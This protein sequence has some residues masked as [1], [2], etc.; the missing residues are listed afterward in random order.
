M[1]IHLSSAQNRYL[2]KNGRVANADSVIEAEGKFVLP[3]GIDPNVNLNKPYEDLTQTVDDFYRGTRAAL[4]GGTTTVVDCVKPKD[5][6]S[7]VEAY[8]KWR[9]WAEG[10][11]CCNYAL[12]MTLDGGS[13]LDEEKM[14]EMEE[15]TGLDFGIN[16][17]K[18]EMKDA[19]DKDILKNLEH[20]RKLG[21]LA[22]ITPESGELT[23]REAESLLERGINGP[24]GFA[25]AHSESAEE[26]AVMRVSTLANHAPCP[27]WVGPVMSVSAAEILRRKK[28]SGNVVFG[29]TIPASL[30]C[31]GN[32]YWNE[33]WRH[34]AGFVTNPPIRRGQKE[35]M[36]QALVNR[37]DSGLDFVSSD[38]ATFNSNQKALGSG[39]FM[40]IP[41]GVNGIEERMAVLWEKAVHT[42]KMD[43]TEFVELT[44]AGPAK[45][46]G[47]YPDKGRIEVGAEADLVV[48]NP[49]EKR[50]ISAK[51]H[52]LKVDFNIFEGMEVHG[53]PETVIC[54]GKIM[55]DEGQIRVMQGFG[56]FIPLSPFNDYVYDKVRDKEMRDAEPRPVI[57]ADEP[58]TS[59]NGNGIPPPTP[60][61]SDQAERAPSQH[62]SNVDLTSHPMGDASPLD[63]LNSPVRA[64]PTRSSVRVR[65]PPGGKSSGGFW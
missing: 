7:L 16:T 21:C 6:E 3:G 30:A 26:E 49:A 57:R 34:A 48:W 37:N 58:V 38:N 25:M 33:C 27:L 55:V 11:V 4:V 56:Q 60:V 28:N 17:F 14:K 2:I 52:Q 65:N 63:N 41:Q 8:H 45:L 42:G 23:R 9:G 50:T 36:V 64:S 61:V 39:D 24:E 59:S 32:E 53:S 62:E 12:R 18:V 54:Q 31:D 51:S 40:K 10:K 43:V 13:S 1:P 20:V 22:Q 44:S 5:G 47:M 35:A 46:L 15:L 29:E 19:K